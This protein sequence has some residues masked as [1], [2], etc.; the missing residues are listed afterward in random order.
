MKRLILLLCLAS[1]SFSLVSGQ[2]SGSDPWYKTPEELIRDI[3][4][5]VSAKNSESVNWQKV[6]SMFIDEAIVVLRTS[7]D[8]STRFTADGFI[9]DLWLLAKKDGLWKITSIVNEVIPYGEE[10]PDEP[11]WK[12]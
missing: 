8:K 7:R 4:V 9:V 10:L 6:R 12:F 5:A 2:L 3:Y 11:E 1:L